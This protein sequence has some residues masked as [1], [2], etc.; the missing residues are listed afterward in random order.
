MRG[1][2]VGGM[3]A[4][5]RVYGRSDHPR[6]YFHDTFLYRIHNVAIGILSNWKVCLE[7][8]EKN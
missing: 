3:A 2:R 5:R 1:A 8:I 6:R 7:L 4:D